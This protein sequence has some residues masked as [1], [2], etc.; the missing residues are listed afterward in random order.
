M[1]KGCH[2]QLCSRMPV[3]GSDAGWTPEMKRWVAMKG[4]GMWGKGKCG[5]GHGHWWEQQEQSADAQREPGAK[6]EPQGESASAATEAPPPS[7]VNVGA[8]WWAMK[9]WG[10]KGKG[11]GLW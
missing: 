10:L 3:D 9:M 11:K 8:Q 2:G 6:E 1:G 7:G 5:K 4:S